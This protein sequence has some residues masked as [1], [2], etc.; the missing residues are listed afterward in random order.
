MFFADRISAMGGAISICDPHRVIVMG[1][2]PLKPGLHTSPD[3]R[4]G[5]ALLIA[6]L[7]PPGFSRIEHVE[8]IDRGYERFDERL[9]ALGARIQRIRGEN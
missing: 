3:I 6:A 7:T 1:P 2:T 9:N 5:V 4:A 8:V